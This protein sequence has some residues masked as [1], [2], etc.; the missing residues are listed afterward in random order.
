[1]QRTAPPSHMVL[2]R[3]FWLAGLSPEPEGGSGGQGDRVAYLTNIICQCGLQDFNR[4]LREEQDA[5]YEAGLAAD[6]ERERQ[7]AAKEQ[8]AREAQEAEDAAA[9]KQQ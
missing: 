5:E 6:Q 7:R 3:S 9:A 2:L 1:M 8:A 4:R